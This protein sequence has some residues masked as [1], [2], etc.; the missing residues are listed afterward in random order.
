MRVCGLKVQ[1]IAGLAKPILGVSALGLCKKNLSFMMMLA[2]YFTEALEN[3]YI[4][5]R[6][7]GQFM[8]LRTLYTAWGNR[9]Y[10]TCN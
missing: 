2:K 9:P 7:Q 1:I 5:C 6:V 10:I 8:C 4:I 3:I